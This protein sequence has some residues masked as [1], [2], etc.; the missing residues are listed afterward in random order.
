MSTKSTI[1]RWGAAALM[2]GM[3][4][5]CGGGGGGETTAAAPPPAVV[6]PAAAPGVAVPTGTAPVTFT[7]LTAAQI[8]ALTPAVTVG[9]VSIS[10][11]PVVTFA[12]SDGATTN[13]AILGITTSQVRFMLAKLVPGTNGSPS[14]WV[15]YGVINSAGTGGQ[16]PNAETNGT[17][18]DNKNGT[19]TYTFANDVAKLK[20]KIAG[21]T[22]TAPESAA[23][24]G[25]LTYDPNLTH[26]LVIQMSGGGLEN[27]VNAVYDFIPATG[28]AVTSTDTQR[29]VV[30]IASCNQCHEKLALHGSARIDTQYCVTCHT[31]QRKFGRTS[32]ASTALAFPALVELAKVDPITGIT[33]YYYSKNTTTTSSSYHPTGTDP[34]YVGDGETMGDF[35][36]MVHK[37]HQGH[38]LV[39]Q[40]YNYANVV[41][42]NKAFSILGDGQKMCA[43][44]HDNTKAAQ[45][46]NF[47][48][49]PSRLACGACHDGIKFSDGTG[50]TLAGAATGHVGKAQ[51]SDAL[52]ALCHGA[53]DIKVYHQ[54]EN[55]TKHN[56]TIAAGLANF[57]YE[58]ASAAVDATTN[59]LTV[60][61]KI[62]KD[63]TALASVSSPPTGFT[64]GPGFILAW[65]FAQDGITTPVDYNNALSATTMQT[66]GEAKSVS[67]ASSAIST[68]DASGYLTA[69][70]SSANG[71]PV[72]A[73][74]R[75]VSLQSYYT[76]SAGTGGIAAN[77]ARHAISVVKE[78][79]GD[80]VRRKVV[81][82]AKCSNCHEWLEL[83]GGSR[84]AAPE[85]TVLMCVM[86]HNPAKATS[87]RGIS[88]AVW[89]TYAASGPGFSAA[90][91]KMLGEWGVST[92]ATERALL[93]PVTSNNMKDMI[94]GIH[95]G[96]D[97]VNPFR[98]ARDR[99]G[100]TP[101]GSTGAITLLDFRR[102]DF[103]G[104]RQNCETCH[105]AGTYASVPANALASTYESINAAYAA[106]ATTANAKASYATPNATDKV[107]SPF[108]AVCSSCHDSVAAQSHMATQGGMIQ[109][110]RAT[111]ATN[112]ATPGKG[113]ACATCHG[114]GRAEDV[115]VKHK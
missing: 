54:M 78:V 79:T 42:N 11:P 8:A 59:V 105:L 2:I 14:K 98:D 101:A 111:F 15:S 27:P 53:A 100:G 18:V 57:T 9:G 44:C 96:R 3:L 29:Q 16:R 74:M 60:V 58:I 89:D 113:E 1:V 103:P 20:D 61:F 5:G 33:S 106:A 19:Y 13:N 28:K 93:L 76:Q 99:T 104:R 107:T 68:P 88:D 56:P 92:T 47:N 83:H 84:V 67:F 38:S 97:R 12:I 35:P 48:A 55:I 75:A 17:L 62:S 63:G 25:D 40:N 34:T 50:T 70:I 26:R 95:S 31:D 49:V 64:G 46:D 82:P 41:F 39:K 4:A 85:S 52:C 77:T 37:I 87:G 73:K 36:R 91:L 81:D 115:T 69:T 22:F 65:A 51:S 24:L 72:G 109:V 102:M 32:V 71:F 23:D 80:T 30:A 6:P 43:K 66:K 114:V 108:A 90:D 112:I 7:A 45:A 110:T 21:L 10:S 94:H 86:C